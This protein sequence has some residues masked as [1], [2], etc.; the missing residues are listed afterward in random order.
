[1]RECKVVGFFFERLALSL[2][3]SSVVEGTPTEASAAFIR[4]HSTSRKYKTIIKTP[5]PNIDDGGHGWVQNCPRCG[6]EIAGIRWPRLSSLT[7]EAKP[8]T[9]SQERV[10]HIHFDSFFKRNAKAFSLNAIVDV[11]RR[12]R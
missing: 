8:F 7:A 4:P 9:C 5:T 12:R 10:L 3:R 2:R 6:L 1:M 11:R